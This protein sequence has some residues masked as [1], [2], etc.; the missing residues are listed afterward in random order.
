VGLFLDMQSVP[1]RTSETTIEE[2]LTDG[3]DYELLFAV[4]KE[5][6]DRLR[7]DWPFPKL[8]LTRLGEFRY[9]ASPGVFD[10][11]G[12]PLA[13]RGPRGFDHFSR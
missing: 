2:A 11:A 1:R 12:S 13:V 7:R 9:S 10:R 4:P 3:E 5:K 8:P 6:E